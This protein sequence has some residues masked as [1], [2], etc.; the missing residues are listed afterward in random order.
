MRVATWNIQ[1]ISTK[2]KEIARYDIDII[3]LSG[4]EWRKKKDKFILTVVSQKKTEHKEHYRICYCEK[5]TR[6]KV[7]DVGP[8]R[9]AERGSNNH[10]LVAKINL[11][12][13][14]TSERKIQQDEQDVQRQQLKSWNIDSLQNDSTRFLYQFRLATKLSDMKDGSPEEIYE[15]L[16]RK[17]HEAGYEALG[18]KSHSNAKTHNPPWWTENLE[19]QIQQKKIADHRWLSTKAQEDRKNYEKERRD[20]ADAIKIS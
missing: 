7:N 6:L 8:L 15:S 13:A 5:N 11:P 16:K 14:A 9:G 20:T 3:A 4:K 18:E 2:V 17:I 12:Y 10:L 1:G 19:E